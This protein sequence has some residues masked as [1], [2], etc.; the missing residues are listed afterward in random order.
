MRARPEIGAAEGEVCFP[1]VTPTSPP[2][3]VLTVLANPVPAKKMKGQAAPS[4]GK[5]AA[6]AGYVV[7]AVGEEEAK[8]HKLKSNDEKGES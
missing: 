1:L 6:L 4:P 3:T 8:S 7:E 5:T 2:M